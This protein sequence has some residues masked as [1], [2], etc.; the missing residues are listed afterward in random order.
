MSSDNTDAAIPNDVSQQNT[1]PPSGTPGNNKVV[2]VNGV[3]CIKDADEQNPSEQPH[4]VD[5]TTTAN[6]VGISR[7][8]IPIVVIY[9]VLLIGNIAILQWGG[10]FTGIVSCLIVGL[11]LA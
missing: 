8:S 5:T 6:T 3:I 2:I 10:I 1:T 9:V 11:F 7:F 4:S